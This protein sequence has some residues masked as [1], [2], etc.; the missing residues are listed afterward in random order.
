MLQ[1]SRLA[2]FTLLLLFGAA[3]YS[4]IYKGNQFEITKNLELLANIFRELDASYVDE[5]T[6]AKLLK[7]GIDGMM[8]SLDPYTTF[9]PEDEMSSYE[10]QTTGK[11]GGIGALIRKSGDYV[12]ITEPYENSPSVKYDLRAGD[13][14]LKVDGVSAKGKNTDEVSKL[15]KGE[16][17]TQVKITIE[18]PGEP[19]PIEK[20]ITREEI[21]IKNVPYYGMLDAQTGYI[22]LTG[23]TDKCSREVSEA[24]KDLKNNYKAQSVVLDL[25]DNPGGLLNEAIDVANVFVDKDMEIVST[26][27]RKRDWDKKYTT[28]HQPV[29]TQMPLVILI[30]R[31]SASAAE[32]VSGALQDLD[33][34]V[35]L[36]DRSFGKGLVQSTKDVGY[37]SRIKLTTAKYYLPSG[38]CI[39]AIDYSGGYS[40]KLEKVP[41]SLRTAF[42]TKN[43]RTVYDAGGV[44]PDVKVEAP[45]YANISNSLYNKQ[46]IF[47]YATLYRTQHPQIAEPNQFELT[48][49][50]FE[51]F[52]KFLADKDYDYTSKSEELLKSLKEVSKK[53]NYQNAINAEL[54]QLENALHHDKKQDLQKNK[55]EIKK[56]LEYEIVSRYYL[57]KGQTEEALEDDEVVLKAKEILQN[58]TQYKQLLG[59]Q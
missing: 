58:P 48:D 17:N 4:F 19:A 26:R 10:L 24:M 55:D 3:S 45:K 54:A 53:E 56:L 50:D 52:T 46:L 43:N 9:I 5:L 25:R 8:S 51:A 18:R 2:T 23:F 49:A 41:D 33:R 13:K 16:P 22:R 59:K 20:V 12:I 27:S 32:I 6:P 39:Q 40:D 44:D 47:D 30:D 57:Q 36:G 31:G 15:L 35:I 14:I 28:H 1:K 11:Y 21:V 38:R 37:N 42:K 7:S 29:D 34:G